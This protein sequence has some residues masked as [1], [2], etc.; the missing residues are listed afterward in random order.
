MVEILGASFF[1]MVG[2]LEALRFSNNW[3]L[4]VLP[5]FV[6]LDFCRPASIRMVELLETLSSRF[7]IISEATWYSYG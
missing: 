5:V 3:T 7:A 1:F 2:L 4:R 6:W